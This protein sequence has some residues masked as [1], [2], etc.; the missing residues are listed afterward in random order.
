MLRTANGN[1]REGG[2]AAKGSFG[3]CIRGRDLMRLGDLHQASRLVEDELEQY[4]DAGASAHVWELRFLRADITRLRGHTE[5]A[6]KYLRECETLFPPHRNDLPS[7]VGLRMNCGYFLGQLGHYAPAHELLREAEQIARASGMLEDQCEI[8]QRQAMIFYLQEDYVTSDHLFRII[9]EASEQIGGWFFKA[10]A[11][12][13]I[14]KNLMIRK[15][16]E[17]ALPWLEEALALFK[18]AGA[19]R[20]M[21]LVWSEMA[22]CHLGLGDDRRS[23]ELLEDALQIQ[24]ELGIVQNYLVVL[25]NIGNVYLH[26]GDH[27]KA[28]DYYRRALALAREIKDLVSVQKWSHNIRFAYARLRESVDRLDLKAF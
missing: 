5:E 14:G 9:L 6:L 28:I 20:S 10:N 11:L 13:G 25:A 18:T 15:Q 16:H 8:Y 19:R 22:V 23:L 4:G 7:L 17:S 2:T 26:R 27:L 3:C 12:W 21:A 24:S 1:K